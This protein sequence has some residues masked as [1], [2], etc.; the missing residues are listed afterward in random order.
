VNRRKFLKILGIGVATP[1]VVG[2]ALSAP[3]P[4]VMH[5]TH[6]LGFLATQ[7]LLDDWDLALDTEWFLR[8][9]TG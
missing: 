6:S 2:K 8:E 9:P 1:F 5:S 7:E 3:V 4:S